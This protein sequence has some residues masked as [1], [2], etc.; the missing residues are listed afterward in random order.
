VK[1]ISALLSA[2]FLPF[3]GVLASLPPFETF[4][5]KMDATGHRFLVPAQI[6]SQPATLA[7]DTGAE[8]LFLFKPAAERLG[9][10]LPKIPSDVLRKGGKFPVVDTKPYDIT[11]FNK[12]SKLPIPVADFSV[13]SDVDGC[14]GWPQF[15]TSIFQIDVANG[16]I[17][18][19][20]QVPAEARQWTVFHIHPSS[21]VLCLELPK[22]NKLGVIFVDTGS[23]SG[24]ALNRDRWRAWTNANPHV[25][26]TLLGYYMGGAGTV[27]A[28]EAWA[29]NL[30]IGPLLLHDVPVHPASAS[31]SNA[32]SWQYPCQATIGLAALQRLDFIIDGPSGVAYVRPRK[33]PFP[34][35]PHN[36]AGVIFTI[37]PPQKSKSG[38]LVAHVVE[39][40]PAYKAG[41]R[42][43]DHLTGFNGKSITNANNGPTY[44]SY[45]NP[46]GTKLNFTL[47]RGETEFDTIV[48]LEDIFPSA[49]S[50]TSG[51]AVQS[52]Q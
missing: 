44:F 43:G 3:S 51:P 28:E 47:K 45:T 11:I 19:L 39:N 27:V 42:N 52:P 1:F 33:G 22:P 32:G 31:E 48:T 36:R 49:T 14:I 30:S 46:A 34:P 12:T 37:Q 38:V 23:F 15:K 6:N 2:F 13:Q 50:D 7:F 4:T 41:I 20:P 35:Y 40:G 25:A 10:E 24:V 16:I 5:A 18:S 29:E 8:T 9:L 17:R 26:K 21:D